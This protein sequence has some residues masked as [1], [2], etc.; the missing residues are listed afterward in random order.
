M[1]HIF[2]ELFLTLDE[3]RKYYPEPIKYFTYTNTMK[4]EEIKTLICPECGF[5][6]KSVFEFSE[7]CDMDQSGNCEDVHY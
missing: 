6:T 3:M 5:T 1:G 7:H 2:F 4:E